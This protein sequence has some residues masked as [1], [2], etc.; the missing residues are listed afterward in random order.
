MK[1]FMLLCVLA[2]VGFVCAGMVDV[3]RARRGLVE[4]GDDDCGKGHFGGEVS[5][6]APFSGGG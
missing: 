1:S 6:N 5:S 2:V 3:P 4:R